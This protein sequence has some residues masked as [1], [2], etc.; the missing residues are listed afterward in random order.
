MATPDEYAAWI[1]KN[2]DKKGTPEFETVAQAYKLS[3]AAPAPGASAS[4]PPEGSTLVDSAKGLAAGAGASF[5]KLV[6][7]AQ[8]FA[9]KGLVALGEMTSDAPTVTNLITE[10][11]PTS[12]LSQAG[13]WLVKDAD[14]G[15]ARL[16]AENAPYKAASPI[17][18]AVGDVGGSIVATLPV[19]GL[20]PAMLR[21]A[22]GARGVVGILPRVGQAAGVGAVYGGVTGTASSNADT[23]G[24][25]LADGAASAGTGAAFGGVSSPVTAGVAA[26]GRNVTQRFSGTA[27]AEFAQQKVAEAFARDA[28]GTLATGGY[29]NPLLQM[30]ARYSKLGDEAVVADAGG[31]N[32]NQLLDTLVTLPGRTKEAAYNM[33]HQRT[34]GVG[35][36]MRTAAEDALGTQGQRL[37]STVE[38]LINRREQASAPLYNQLR[39][40]EIQPSPQLADIVKAAD[41]L[42]VTKLGREIATARQMPFTLDATAPARWNM[43]DLD[44]VKQGI[45]QVLASR[46]ALNQDG[47]LT[48]VGHAYQALK[49]QLVDALDKATTNPQTGA[50]LYRSARAAFS[51]PSSLIDA[52]NAGRSA[53]NR[54]EGSILKTV[55]GMSD[56]EREAFRIG[57]YEGLHAKLGTQSG[58]TNIM[59]MWKEPATQEKLKAIFGSER[60]YREFAASVAKEA[61]LK[62]LQS[63]G[64]GSQ[65]AARQAGMG[66]LDL[67]ALSDAGAAVG[68]AKT[69]NLLSAIGSAKNAWNRVAVPQ[70]VRD[71]MGNML[72]SR[73]P[74]GEQ[75]LNS[76]A[77]LID[78]INTRNMLLSNGVGVASGVTGNA[79]TRLL[80]QPPQQ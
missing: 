5:G 51:T 9:G 52:A 4:K 10:K 69:G 76:L 20:L 48:P 3:R 50:S 42:G 77:P 67:S 17:A 63:V 40:V 73:G 66:D 75:T 46:K 27:A 78:M 14:A 19:G 18:N 16:E 56:P 11:K 49:T 68:A 2:A 1:V 6:L 47:T 61:Q 59:N 32:T 54:D 35:D 23:L 41:D 79:L 55:S 64:T 33:L 71:Q 72:L 37:S 74:A 8:R 39:Q 70:T 53:I 24:G 22:A 62:R 29:T 80:Q 45:D 44:H 28:R 65:T 60:S 15:K 12:L 26:V 57:A 31:R 38:A 7:G 21:G 43:G 13:Q 30:A 25:M 34:A 58:Q 36:R